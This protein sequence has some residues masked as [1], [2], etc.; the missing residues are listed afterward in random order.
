MS[1]HGGFE[2][3][4]AYQLV[5]RGEEVVTPFLGQWVWKANIISRIQTLCGCV[6]V[7]A[8]ALRSALPRGGGDIGGSHMPF[9]PL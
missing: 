9:M 6:Y 4:S 5:T 7:I 3:K 1:T 8:S 2:L